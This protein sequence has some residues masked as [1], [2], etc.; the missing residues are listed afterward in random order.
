MHLVFIPAIIFPKEGFLGQRINAFLIL[1]DC[2]I[3]SSQGLLDVAIFLSIKKFQER[4]YEL[5]HY[6]LNN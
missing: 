2:A 6:D 1:I 3:L 5:C 4:I